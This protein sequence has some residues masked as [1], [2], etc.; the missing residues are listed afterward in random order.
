M[1][2]ERF[3]SATALRNVSIVLLGITV[4]NIVTR[5]YLTYS[6]TNLLLGNG[7]FAADTCYAENYKEEIYFSGLLI[8]PMILMLQLI[9][10]LVT[11]IAVDKNRSRMLTLSTYL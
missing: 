7:Q 1:S 6:S 10:A 5:L 4:T 8:V 9:S 2:I 11:I 3:G